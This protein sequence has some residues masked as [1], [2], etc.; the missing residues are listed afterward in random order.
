MLILLGY[1]IKGIKF[2]HTHI[3]IISIVSEILTIIA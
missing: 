3:W 1:K 2:P